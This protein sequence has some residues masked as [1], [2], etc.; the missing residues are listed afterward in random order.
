LVKEGT[1]LLFALLVLAWGKIQ[2]LSPAA[3][4][5][6]I[7]ELLCFIMDT[8]ILSKLEIDTKNI[9]LL[10]ELLTGAPLTPEC[11]KLISKLTAL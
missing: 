10:V 11:A 2:G 8:L 4:K 9:I 6:F 5:L 7:A 1:S 3:Q